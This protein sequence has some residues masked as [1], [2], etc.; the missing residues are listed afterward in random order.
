MS[1]ALLVVAGLLEIVWA[2]AIKQSNDFTRL[3]P[4]VICVVAAAVSFVSSYTS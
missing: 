4:S 1:S 2:T 3:W